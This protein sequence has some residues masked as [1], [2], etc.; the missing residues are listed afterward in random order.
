MPDPFQILSICSFIL[1]AFHFLAWSVGYFKQLRRGMNVNLQIKGPTRGALDREVSILRHK[2]R[3]EIDAQK[4]LEQTIS[5]NLETLEDHVV[6]EDLTAGE[7]IE[8]GEMMVEVIE[9]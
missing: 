5:N 7:I 2:F 8:M 4:T 6:V 3:E 1:A 9:I